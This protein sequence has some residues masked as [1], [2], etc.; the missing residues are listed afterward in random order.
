MITEANIYIAI[1]TTLTGTVVF[2]FGLLVKIWNGRAERIIKI[3]KE[4][5]QDR[6]SYQKQQKEER[7]KF[8]KEQKE[9]QQKLLVLT[10]KV[11]RLEG[12][13]EAQ[14]MAI[15][16]VVGGVTKQIQES[17]NQFLNYLKKRDDVQ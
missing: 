9:V 17:N 11:E 5:N 16:T 7:E 2:L 12:G 3:E 4:K 8:E 14:I 6:E 10:G 1:G 15:E 13:K